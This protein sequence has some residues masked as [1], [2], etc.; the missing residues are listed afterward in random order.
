M[1]K[2]AG[3]HSC[4]ESFQVSDAEASIRESGLRPNWVLNQGHGCNLSRGTCSSRGIE[5]GLVRLTSDPELC[6]LVKTQ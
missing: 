5:A 4:S 3:Q 2:I 1:A 6:T